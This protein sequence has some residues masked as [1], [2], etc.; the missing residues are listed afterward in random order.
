MLCTAM[1]EFNEVINPVILSDECFE[2]FQIHID[3]QRNTP[4]SMVVDKGRMIRT[5]GDYA[6]SQHF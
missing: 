6:G 5:P 2:I 4:F 1:D 3:H